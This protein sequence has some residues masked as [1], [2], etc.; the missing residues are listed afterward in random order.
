MKDIVIIANFCRD[1]S[2]SDNGR[3]MYLAKELSANN[4]V[5]IITSTFDHG[6]KTQRSPLEKSWPFKIT[7]LHEPGYNKNISLQRFFSHSAWGKEVNA[8]LKKRRRPDV[9]FCA[10]PSLTAP[11]FAAKY[12]E[13]NGI[14]FIIDIQDL[15]PEAFRMVFHVPGISNLVFFPFKCLANAIYRRADEIVAVSQTYADRALEVNHKCKT[16]QAVF[17]GTKLE[18]FDKNASN[19][20]VPK[21]P[22]ELWLGYCGTL[23]SS[24]DLVCVIDALGILKERNIKPPLFIV[25]GDGPQ[26]VKLEKYAN[27]KKIT[28]VFTG[29]LPYEKMC[30]ML[31]CC[32]MTVNP[33]TQGAAQSIINKHGDYAAAG[34]PVVSTQEC[35]EY[36]HLVENYNMGFNCRNHDAKDLAEKLS[37]LIHNEELRSEMGKNARRCAKE[38]FDRVQEYRKICTMITGDENEK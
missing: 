26:R 8:Y 31:A 22:G 1:F 4:K 11:F 19:N 35:Q 33:I 25:M 21:K 28:V 14:R 37:V 38:K 9:V 13:K 2:E 5:E 20:R 34:L 29:R 10:I 32:D 6:T 17:L 15:W 24:Y 27:E 18:T 12:C 36:R 3:F 23:G 30:G 16:G 7:F